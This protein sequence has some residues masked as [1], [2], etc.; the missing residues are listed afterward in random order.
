MGGEQ[1]DINTRILY[2]SD[3]DFDYI[4]SEFNKGNISV[5]VQY[6]PARNQLN[7]EFPKEGRYIVYEV[8][9]GHLVIMIQW[10]NSDSELWTQGTRVIG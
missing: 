3:T 10:V 9:D 5:F 6:D 1:P 7:I 2:T 4:L 8:Q